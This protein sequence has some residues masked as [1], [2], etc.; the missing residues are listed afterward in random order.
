[1]SF[2]TLKFAIF[3]SFLLVQ[4]FEQ[5][6][7]SAFVLYQ[8]IFRLETLHVRKRMYNTI[9]KVF[10]K[11]L[12]YWITFLYLAWLSLVVLAVSESELVY[13]FMAIQF[14]GIIFAL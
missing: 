10:A 3:C 2:E 7:L 5:Q 1:M 12:N 6:I 9:E 11:A 8:Q 14:L 4:T 13:S